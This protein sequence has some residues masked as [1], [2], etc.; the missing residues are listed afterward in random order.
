[1]MELNLRKP[2][3]F[4]CLLIGAGYYLRTHCTLNDVL[5]YAK[6][7]PDPSWAPPVDYYIGMVHYA[8]DRYQPASEAFQQLLT[9]YPTSYY[10]PH[11]LFRLGQSY[12]SMGNWQGAREAYEKYMERYPQGGK[13]QLVRSK[14]EL[15]KF[16]N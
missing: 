11:G 4:L 12:E 9:D 5:A 14:Y 7:H 13:I 16:R 10:A 1:M 6:R 15:I 3:I 8:K 2:L